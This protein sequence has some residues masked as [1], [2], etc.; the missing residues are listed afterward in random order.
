MS[1]Q[2]VVR[3]NYGVEEV[4]LSL[5]T[6]EEG[7]RGLGV[8]PVPVSRVEKRLESPWPKEGLRWTGLESPGPRDVLRE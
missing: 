5:R 4:P 8:Q 7:Q 2:L 1:Q 3:R 6:A